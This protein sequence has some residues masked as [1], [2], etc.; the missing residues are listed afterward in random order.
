M[1]QTTSQVDS[2]TEW[3][4]NLVA[5]LRSQELQLETG[6]ASVE[7]KLFY[8]TFFA[9][10]VDAIVHMGKNMAQKH[11]VARII[12]DFLTMT[13]S[14]SP[15]KIAFDYNDSE[16]LVWAEIMENDEA[17]ERALLVAQA[18]I[19]AKYHPFGFD[20]ETTIVEQEDA[21]TIPNHYKIY[22]A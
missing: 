1:E 8:E 13:K 15:L 18:H 19:N 10:N 6:I 22:K 5:T 21:L 16:V 11:F 7:T 14:I 4:D 3:F 12:F 2:K 20:M 9:G 17:T